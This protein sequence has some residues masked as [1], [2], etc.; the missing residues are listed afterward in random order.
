MDAK[1]G[2]ADCTPGYL[3]LGCLVQADH[4]QTSLWWHWGLSAQHSESPCAVTPKDQRDWPFLILT[5]VLYFGL[6]RQQQ[7]KKEELPRA[8]SPPNW[9]LRS[10][11][12]WRLL[13]NLKPM[14]C[15]THQPVLEA[16][17]ILFQKVLWRRYWTALSPE[18]QLHLIKQP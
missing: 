8:D 12:E 7:K 6:G 11:E 17:T 18:E 14:S 16:T 13:L 2:Q 9:D 10:Q 4:A 1:Q 15:Q 5:Q 3:Q